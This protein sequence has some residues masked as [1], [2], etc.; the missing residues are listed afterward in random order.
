MS[1]VMV[2]PHPPGASLGSERRVKE[3]AL[4]LSSALPVRARIYSPFTYGMF[5]IA[6]K[7]GKA[8]YYSKTLC[9]M[10]LDRFLKKPSRVVLHR[11]VAFLER[12]E[13]LAIQ[14]ELDVSLS[15]SILASRELDLPIVADL[16][17]IISEELV[18][19]G[20]ITRGDRTYR[21]LQALM[22]DWLSQVDLIC[23]V[24]NEMARY[25]R[26]HYD[27]ERSKLVIV[28]PG[29]RPRTS[30]ASLAARQGDKVVYAGSLSYREHVDLFVRSAPIIKAIRPLVILYSTGKGE[31]A[32]KLMTLSRKLRA[33]IKFF[34][35]SGE[36]QLFRFLSS[37][38]VAVLPS[39]N[40]MAR[41]MGIPIKM[42]DYLSVGLPVVANDIGGW[43]HMIDKLG[44]GL[45]TE[46]DP[47]DFALGI[48]SLLND[49]E[50]RLRMSKKALEL[51]GGELNWKRTAKPLINA[52]K[53]II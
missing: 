12:C 16:H 20:V 52:Y 22:A 18:A 13:A 3:L 51:V 49:D 38:S 35:A 19:A 43:T 26:E 44:I 5:R 33:G 10:L 30:K 50:V 36:E 23:V 8:V 42:L 15:L 34:W 29:G 32:R 31:N 24:S 28:M 7:L 27:I 21:R 6:Y 37:C 40:D 14:A 11:L 48:T 53:K 9:K 45:L 47:R 41:K 17:N 4:E 2:F 25:V 46:D 1:I 39:S